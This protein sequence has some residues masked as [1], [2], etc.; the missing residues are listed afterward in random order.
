VGCVEGALGG[1][2]L[3]QATFNVFGGNAAE[4]G[5]SFASL[6]FTAGADVLDDGEFSDATTTALVTFGVG[7]LMTDPIGDLVVDGYAS[8]Y[9]H[10]IFNGI[11]TIFNGGSFLR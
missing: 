10:G 7:G 3:G 1:L 11:E 8:G 9:N 6:I 4:T 2:L 5:L